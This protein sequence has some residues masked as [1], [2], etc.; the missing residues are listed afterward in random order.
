M[1]ATAAAAEAYNNNNCTTCVRRKR[2][3]THTHTQRVGF[4]GLSLN[5][6]HRCAYRGEPT[7]IRARN[8][9]RVEST[10]LT[11]SYNETQWIGHEAII[12]VY[13]INHT[14]VC[15]A[16][17][18]LAFTTRRNR[19][20]KSKTACH[21]ME[22]TMAFAIAFA[23]DMYSCGVSVQHPMSTHICVVCGRTLE[24]WAGENQCLP[25]F[26]VGELFC[27]AHSSSVRTATTH[28]I[29]GASQV[30]SGANV[31]YSLNQNRN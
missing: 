10:W 12:C 16:Q 9:M 17:P 24:E 1:A 8:K 4:E 20:A 23:L 25:L 19:D 22:R 14:F 5:E 11:K 29:F 6:T 3:H 26:S 30:Q 21:G 13:T 7:G 31:N 18:H 28:H 27:H 15:L 2:Q